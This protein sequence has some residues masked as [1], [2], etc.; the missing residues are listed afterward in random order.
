MPVAP[1]V[2]V[3]VSWFSPLEKTTLFVCLPG[4]GGLCRTCPVRVTESNP[5]GVARSIGSL[6]EAAIADELRDDPLLPVF[7]WPAGVQGCQVGGP[8]LRHIDEVQAVAAATFVA[9]TKGGK[10]GF[11]GLVIIVE[12][13]EKGGHPVAVAPDLLGVAG[14]LGIDEV[15]VVADF[16]SPAVVQQ[17]DR[18]EVVEGRAERRGDAVLQQGE[19]DVGMLNAKDGVAVVARGV[20][21]GFL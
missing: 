1:G 16:L 20:A 13:D 11:T 5:E 21:D 12:I 9:Q 6:Q 8:V 7:R 14:R 4:P 10:V 17:V 19:G 18:L 15:V 3:Q 2:S